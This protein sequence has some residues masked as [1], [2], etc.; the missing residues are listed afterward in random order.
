MEGMGKII[1]GVIHNKCVAIFEVPSIT[2]KFGKESMV[3]SVMFLVARRYTIIRGADRQ[4][5]ENC[6]KYTYQFILG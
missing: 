2:R 1:V 5:W 4:A 6:C 3:V